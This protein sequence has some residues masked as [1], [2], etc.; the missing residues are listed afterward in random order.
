MTT[1]FAPQDTY[2]TTKDVA[3]IIGVEVKTL[4]N[5]RYLGKGPR[6]VKQGG[7][8]RYHRA[9]LESWHSEHEVMPSV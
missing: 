4:H 5:W 3:R 7:V 6:Y 1:M 9:A 2:L 8:V